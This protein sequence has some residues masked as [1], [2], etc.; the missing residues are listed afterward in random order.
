MLFIG[1]DTHKSSLAVCV[2]DELGRQLAVESFRN[3]AWASAAPRVG[4]RGGAAAAAVR[5]REQ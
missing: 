2:V 5:D 1:I 4:G 3:D